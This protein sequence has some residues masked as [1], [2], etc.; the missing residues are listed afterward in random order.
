[1]KATTGQVEITFEYSRHVGP[2][3]DHGGVTISFDAL[4][5]YS[6]SSEAEWPSKSW[7]QVEIEAAIRE[8][9]EEVLRARMGTLRMVRVILKA[10]AIH[11]VD[12]SVH[13]FRNAAR[14]ATEAAFL[15]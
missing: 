3:Y 5:P 7:S 6:F 4:Q 9:V 15:A 1:M 14:V 12:S 10:V 8:S 13:G 2:R 11:P